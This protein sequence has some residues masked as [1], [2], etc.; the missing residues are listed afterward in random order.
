MTLMRKRAFVIRLLPCLMLAVFT[1]GCRNACC[2]LPPVGDRAGGP[3]SPGA[4]GD[5]AATVSGPDRW[6][7]DLLRAIREALVVRPRSAGGTHSVDAATVA[8]IER[9]LAYLE[10]AAAKKSA[11]IVFIR[12]DRTFSVYYAPGHGPRQVTYEQGRWRVD[13]NEVVFDFTHK[14]GGERAEPYAWRESRDNEYF[15][16]HI[17]LGEE[18]YHTFNERPDLTARAPSDE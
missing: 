3:Y 14:D 13:G 7:R 1:L 18:T 5:D 6:R 9:D 12:A 15:S 8:K 4:S 17:W 10:T 2:L 11:N 16:T